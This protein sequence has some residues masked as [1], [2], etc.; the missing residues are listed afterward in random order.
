M[1]AHSIILISFLLGFSS[2]ISQ[3]APPINIPGMSQQGIQTP[4]EQNLETT[5]KKKLINKGIQS[6]SDREV[7]ALLN[8]YGIST[9]GSI[10][11]K[12]EKLLNLLSP[13][14][15]S[16]LPPPNEILGAE[17]KKKPPIQIQ[18]ASE[19]ELLSIDQTKSGVFVLRGRVEV[20]VG[21]GILKADS[22][23]VDSQRQEVYAEGGIEYKEGSLKVKGEKFLYDSKLN[24]GVVYDTKIS[25]YPSYYIGEKFKK[26]D[27]QRYLLE[28]GYFT[29]C[30][31]EIPHYSFQAKKILIHD[32]G[33]V[34]AYN[35][36]YKVGSST[37]FWLPFLYN[38]PSGNG[39]IMQA[40]KNQTQGFFLQNSY[41]WSNPIS[42]NG[43]L[44]NGYK[45]RADY[46]EKTGEATQLQMWKLSPWLNYDINIGYA[47]HKKYAT[48]NAFE[49]RF[50]NFGIGNVVITNQVDK[51]E[52]FPG[53]GLP[54]R[55]YG[56][57]YEPW[58]KV[59]FV[60]NSKQF[61]T[62][63]DINR[64]IQIRFDKYTNRTFDYEYGNRFEPSNT[65]Q[66]LYTRRDQRFGLIR[67]ALTW[68]FDY[69]ENRG[70][71]SVNVGMRRNLVYYFLNPTTRSD[72]FPTVDVAPITTI[73]NSSQIGLLPYFQTPIYWDIYFNNSL[74]RYYGAPQKENLEYYTYIASI[75]DF[76]PY[77]E[78]I[79]NSATYKETI[80]RTQGFTRGENGFR[81][82][83][84]PNSL[85]SFTPSVY[86]GAQRETVDF[87]NSSTT[88]SSNISLETS[89]KQNS[90]Q[91]VRQ[92]HNFRFG[93]PEIFLNATYR[94]VDSFKPDRVDPIL[95]TTRQHE[96][97][98]AL[99]SY[100]LQ[101]WEVS[102]RT[103]RDMRNISNQYQN[104]PSNNDRW[105]YTVFRFSGFIDFVDGVRA[106]RP[107]L[108]ER[109]RSFYSGV[110][111]N[112]DFVYHSPQGRP[113]SNQFT[114]SY[115][116]GGFTFPFIKQFRTFEMGGTWYHV[117]RDG[118]LDNYR[119]FLKTDVKIATSTGLE[120]ELDSRVTEP[121]RYTQERAV[122][123]NYFG[124]YTDL[125]TY[126][127]GINYD[128]TSIW[129]DLAYGTGAS[130]S[131]NKKK[132]ALNVNRY[133]I[134]LKHNLHSWEYRLTYSMDLR[135]LPG[136][137][138]GDSV[139]TFYD[140]SL[141][142]SLSLTNFSLGSDQTSETSRVRLFRYR[143]QPLDALNP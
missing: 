102:V 66:S 136:G 47:N 1:K 124:S 81:T 109:Q 131:E 17:K 39:W 30:N 16:N 57:D 8:E 25:S 107:T 130:G 72:Y 61:D 108:V 95:G 125:F 133:M 138:S 139:L 11:S 82:S 41:Q 122:P 58:W 18:N 135:A 115:K 36:N 63:K 44:A 32:E 62:A 92:N 132:T 94:K 106:R 59:N 26:I 121:W 134:T 85:T 43:I 28:M 110:F 111:I 129:R 120:M 6:I 40:G 21:N 52:M 140:Q 53:S 65:I 42:D 119:L 68:S 112:N 101:D 55:N 116:M 83:I 126:D 71:L 45:L 4:P 98:L 105:Y 113:L 141:F 38:S 7:D 100:A 88:S 19:G 77:S 128:Q 3:D 60:M 56:V 142:F 22:V 5:T 14:V 31:A 114:M 87:P 24:K 10:Y 64:N 20:K 75:P 79:N 34:V 84:I 69:T 23:T 104:Q 46:Y 97:E 80:L 70:D 9:D 74:T 143:K 86:F 93:I 96:L 27:D 123:G 67:N 103:I 33:T 35:I 99:E 15:K 137:I 51:G 89:L 118:F 2:L 12:R 49:D 78:R 90:F 117:Y 48:T 13:E 50:Q 54:Y 127:T 91:Y 73:K 37:V 76:T 29:T